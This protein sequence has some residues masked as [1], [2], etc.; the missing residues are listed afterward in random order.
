MT[1]DEH[2]QQAAAHQASVHAAESSRAIAERARR[3]SADREELA[4][5]LSALKRLGVQSFKGSGIDVV[6][7]AAVA[8]EEK[9]KKPV[10]E[11]ICACGH[12]KGI[13][14][15]NGICVEGCASEQCDPKATK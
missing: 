12:H 4:A 8:A 5:D 9:A 1:D 11:D 3:V 14:H 15:T 10:D 2:Q 13:A 7:F 6:F